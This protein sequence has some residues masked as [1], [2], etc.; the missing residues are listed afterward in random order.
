M[1]TISALACAMAA[2]AAASTPPAFQRTPPSG[3]CFLLY[4]IGVGEVRRNPSAT[5]TTR[6][7]PQST[8]KIPHAIA[9]L[10]AGVIADA[11]TLIK[12]DG[13]EVDFPAWRRD[14]TLASAMRASVVWYFQEI[15]NRLGPERERAYLDKF[16]Y[17]NRDSSGGL[18]TFWLGRS[19]AISPEE[20]LR[21]LQRLYGDA[22][23][24]QKRAAEIV[25]RILIQDSGSIA[26]A[27]GTHPFGRPWPD[28]TV[29][30]A[31]TG[32]GSAGEGTAV[33]WLVG[34]VRRGER[35][36]IFVSNVIGPPATPALAA[37]EQAER[38]LID[39]RVLR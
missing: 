10:D 33:R 26:N 14:H 11:D 17:G 6:I 38:G 19:L 36:W 1:R 35:G 28:G 32:S 20:Q 8:F 27:L 15:A 29:L 18:T 16:E 25:R 3:G 23:P 12:Y 31:K 22:L 24:V 7:A 2:L 5:C 4:E 39:A 9:A 21:F 37:V 13:R 30:S 34:H